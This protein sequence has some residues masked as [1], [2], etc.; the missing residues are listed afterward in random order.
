MIVVIA[1]DLTG[2]A[3]LGG[4]GL[5]HGLTVE[6]V[7]DIDNLSQKDLLVIATDTRSMPQQEA[8]TVMAGIT[9]KLPPLKPGPIYK[10]VDSVLRGH[11][12]AELNVHLKELG[13]KRA[14]LVSANP[15]FGRTIANGQY[16]IHGQPIHLTSFA[17]DPEFA[18][19][20]SSVYDMLR[21]KDDEIH[22]QT[23]NEDLPATG[24]V[25]GDCVDDHDLVL[26]AKKADKETLMAGGAGLF[27]ALLDP[28]NLKPVIEPGINNIEL[29]QPSLFVCGSTFD[30]SKNLV[31][32][33]KDNN[34]PVSYM[35]ADIVNLANP[36]ESLFE[37]WAGEVASMLKQYQKAIV[38][39]NEDTII[40]S[41]GVGLR[42]KMARVVEKVFQKVV[43]RELLIEGG[44]TAAAIIKQLNFNQ[45]YP[46]NE[47][48]M[49]V[50]RMK[51]ENK[52]D[53]FLTLKPG[54]YDWPRH[55]WSF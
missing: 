20:S 7:T 3:E 39:I 38:A 30:K 22:F 24:I 47:F 2:A 9:A 12:I 46:I 44:S 29:N 32:Q 28:L 41:A 42:E 55:T 13:L 1:D 6:I 31:K 19:T 17:N 48:S 40:G 16:L 53:L 49:G 45:F 8:L 11:V 26:W 36:P 54:S 35:P 14:I 37:E 15:G 18:I 33:V 52:E 4:L 21:A 10:K 43:I 27:N 50:I 23:A 5:R 51:V 34:G 25:A